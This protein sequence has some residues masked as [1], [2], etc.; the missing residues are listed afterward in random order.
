M[1]ILSDQEI[2]SLISAGRLKIDPPPALAAVSPSTI[3]LTLAND[4]L[5]PIVWGGDAAAT[6]IDT[7]DSRK[8]MEALAD[9][10]SGFVVPDGDSFELAP[11]RF[12]LAWT[13][14]RISLPNFLAARVEGRS[15][16]ARLGL[17]VHQSAPTVH[18]TFEGRLQLELTNAGPFALKLYPGQ[19]I[20]QLVVETMSLPSVKPLVSTHTSLARERSSEEA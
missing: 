15:T 19:R 16:P 11:G 1:A 5:V 13:R 12:A 2:W 8:V 18:P 20:C 9:L 6:S 14:E 4:F 17:S 3:D 7:R 10:S